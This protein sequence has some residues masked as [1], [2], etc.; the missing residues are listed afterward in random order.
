MG[1][2]TG[3]SWAPD[4]CTL[5]ADARLARAA[6]FGDLLTDT[7]AALE[8]LEPTRLRL[9]LHPD[10]RVAARAAGL[11]AAETACCSFFTFALTAAAG[12][13]VLDITVPPAQLPVL[14]ALT[15]R[16]TAAVSGTSAAD[17]S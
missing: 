2:G 14:D 8:R 1:A 9:H 6:E 10:P 7:V 5:S 11:A 13:L 3:Q 12:S 17:L 16:A 15:E 4:A